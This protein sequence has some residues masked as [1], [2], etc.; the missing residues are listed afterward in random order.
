M[1]V[2]GIVETQYLAL[3]LAWLKYRPIFQVVGCRYD[4][5]ISCVSFFEGLSSPTAFGTS[6][7]GIRREKAAEVRLRKW[8][9]AVEA[10]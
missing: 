10:G 2:D 9:G 8:R 6:H 7:S 1:L 5:R 4:L 3:F